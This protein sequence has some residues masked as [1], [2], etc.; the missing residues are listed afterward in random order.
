MQSSLNFLNLLCVRPMR[1]LHWR[2]TPP[3]PRPS[4]PLISPAM[5]PIPHPSPSPALQPYYLQWINQMIMETLGETLPFPPKPPPPLLPSPPPAKKESPKSP[6]SP[7]FLMSFNPQPVEVSSYD[8]GLN[9]PYT[10]PALNNLYQPPPPA[11]P[12]P[13]SSLN[14]AVVKEL[15]TLFASLLGK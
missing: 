9:Y 8:G 5:L 14:A 7:P 10:N 4:H 1:R 3:T 12:P 11:S 15:L 2:E 13:S 6:P